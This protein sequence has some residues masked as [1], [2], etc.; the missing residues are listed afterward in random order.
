MRRLGLAFWAAAV[1]STATVLAHADRPTP[2]LSPA[3]V[4]YL[5]APWGLSRSERVDLVAGANVAR[6]VEFRRGGARYVGGVSYQKVQARPERVLSA[7]SS[8][9]ALTEVLPRTKAAELVAQHNGVSHV[10]LTQGNGV[11]DATYTVRLVRRGHEVRFWLDPDRPHDID[12]VWGYF[13]VQPFGDGA[14]LV[15]VAVALD[16]GPGLA[17][18][19]F[20]RRIQSVILGTPRKIRDFIET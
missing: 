9:T 17:R 2:T 8:V 18:L 7:L 14:S 1:V 19:L 4:R 16:L 10:R 6:A 11:V 13:R 5:P 20:E 15:T 3:L 12:D